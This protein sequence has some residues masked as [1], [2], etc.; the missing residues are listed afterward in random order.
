MIDWLIAAALT[1][2][3]SRAE[4][5]NAA[6]PPRRRPAA[7]AGG[8][9]PATPAMRPFSTPL[10]WSGTAAGWG[11]RCASCSARTGE[12]ASAARWPATGSIASPA[13]ASPCT[14]PCSMRREFA[15]PR[16]RHQGPD[17]HARGAKHA[18]CRLV[19]RV[20]S[21][22][23]LSL[24][25]APDRRALTGPARAGAQFRHFGGIASPGITPIGLTFAS[26]FHV[27]SRH[28]R[29][30]CRS[31]SIPRRLRLGPPLLAARNPTVTLYARFA[32]HLDACSTPSRP[33][34][35]CRPGW[36][37][38]PSRSSRRAIPPMA[39][40]PP[41]RRWCWPSPPAP[42]RARWPS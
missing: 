4:P 36:S 15:L 41:M 31:P 12:T 42:I 6:A 39:I 10:P 24:R 18:E 25:R 3:A 2:A 29:G 32:A 7:R 30:P 22:A 20:L 21:G 17:A 34:A 33:K 1:Q 40:S 35:R 38:A 37:A 14:S 27:R 26:P 5:C 23:A 8:P 9:W 11:P 13:P 28:A 19:R 16:G